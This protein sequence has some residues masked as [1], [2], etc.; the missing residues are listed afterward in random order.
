VTLLSLFLLFFGQENSRMFAG[1]QVH[2]FFSSCK[3]GKKVQE[4][5]EPGSDAFKAK[6]GNES[7]TC[8]PI[9][10]FE[11]IKVWYL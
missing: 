8:G 4:L 6:S 2:P 11:N 10:V 1:R 7:I 5:S 3:A 9:H